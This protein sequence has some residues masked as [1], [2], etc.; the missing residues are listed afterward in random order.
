MQAQ[1]IDEVIKLLDQIVE[2]TKRTNNPAGYFAALYRKVTIRVKEG[3]QENEF[4]D[5]ARMER[6]D[7]IFANRY[8]V[9]YRTFYK[10]EMPTASW[11]V[12]LRKASKFWPIVL[13]HLLWGMNAHINLDLGIAAA[14]TASGTSIDHLK[15]DFDQIN[16]L[17]AELVGEVQNELAQIWPTLKV[18]LALSGKF[19]D[20]LIN[21]SMEK[22][23][24]GAWKFATE[25]HAADPQDRKGMIATRDT[26][27]TEI[28]KFIHAPGLVPRLIFGLIRLGERGTIR[29]RIEILE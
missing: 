19:D 18:I 2:E 6:L 24:D 12:A 5:G 20:F 25:L 22:A 1:T 17:L 10:Q 4:E 14:E 11:R 9:A 8:L 7:V 29:K 3:I 16:K 27:I 28:A 21:F 26:R 23:R 15:Q 13:Q